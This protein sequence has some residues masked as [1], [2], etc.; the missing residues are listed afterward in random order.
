MSQLSSQALAPTDIK[1]PSRKLA[2]PVPALLQT[3]AHEIFS[4]TCSGCHG[5]TAQPGANGP[6]LFSEDF[7]NGHTDAQIVQAIND[8]VPGTAMPSFK[9]LLF[10]DEM[11]QMPAYLRIRGGIVNR[12]VGPVPDINGKVFNTQKATFKAETLVKGLDQPWGMAFL[13]DGRLIFTERAGR[14]RFMDK[15]GKMSDPVKG[16]PSVFVRQD[17]GMLDV[18]LSPDYAKT[19]WIYLSYSTVPPGYQVQPGEDTAPNVSAPTM[20][21]IVRGKVNANNEWVDQQILFNPPPEF[22]SGQRRPLRF[23]LPVRS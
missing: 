16:T 1:I 2:A 4:T 13:P 7:L 3:R 17:G 23:A 12:H 5:V 11:A 8:G 21:Y 6:S 10:P 19:G 9:T 20:T 14:L 22:L 15:N 18:A